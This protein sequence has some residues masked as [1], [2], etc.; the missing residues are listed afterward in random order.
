[1]DNIA[2]VPWLAI[3]LLLTIYFSIPLA[4]RKLLLKNPTRV[5]AHM[6]H[7]MKDLQNKRHTLLL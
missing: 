3:T 7:I 4:Y 2:F 6:C 5:D 1:M